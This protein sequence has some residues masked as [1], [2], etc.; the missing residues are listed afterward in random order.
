MRSRRPVRGRSLG[1]EDERRILAGVPMLKRTAK[2]CGRAPCAEG[3][4]KKLTRRGL[5]R[6]DGQR[7]SYRGLWP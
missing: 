1:R 4:R 7:R 3:L 5:D 2:N 6:L